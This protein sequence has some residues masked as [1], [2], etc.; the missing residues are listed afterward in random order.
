[1]RDYEIEDSTSTKP[2]YNWYYDAGMPSEEEGLNQALAATKQ[3]FNPVESVK[4]VAHMLSGVA[5]DAA[6]AV[7]AEPEDRAPSFVGDTLDVIDYA[8][9]NPGAAI[10][11]LATAPGAIPAAMAGPGM[12]PKTGTLY[13][14]FRK[15]PGASKV[16]KRLDGVGQWEYDFFDEPAVMTKFP[17]NWLNR[18]SDKKQNLSPMDAE[19]INRNT[20]DLLSKRDSAGTYNPRLDSV[21]IPR[22]ARSYITPEMQDS[23]RNTRR[24]EFYHAVSK[25]TGTKPLNSYMEELN[26]NVAGAKSISKGMKKWGKSLGKGHYPGHGGRAVGKSTQLLGAGLETSKGAVGVGP[27]MGAAQK[28]DFRPHI[29]EVE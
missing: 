23:V 21:R 4:G 5:N 27:L 12:V 16:R 13:S 17:D 15:R 6:R 9:E 18:V 20:A 25:N 2:D 19:D 7:G 10:T 24:H 8:V 28:Q 29:Y 22:S 11:G 1:M 26:A 3:A 14:T